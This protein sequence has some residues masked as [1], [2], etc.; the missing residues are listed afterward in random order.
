MANKVIANNLDVSI[1][2]IE[3][4]RRDIYQKMKAESAVDLVRM[5][6]QADE[7]LTPGES[8]LT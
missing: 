6:I 4:R 2:T 8:S 1:R 3:N 5:V 7:D